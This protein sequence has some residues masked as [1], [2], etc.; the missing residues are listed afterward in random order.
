[1]L[2]KV[3]ISIASALLT[4]AL[5]AQEPDS[6][7]L[8]QLDSLL[9]QYYESMMFDSYEEKCNEC[10]YLISSCTDSLLRQWVA[11]RILEHYMEPPLMGEEAVGL[12]VYDNWFANGKVVIADEAVDFAAHLFSRF[13]RSSMVGMTAPE[14]ELYRPAGNTLVVPEKGK[15]TVMFFYDTSCTKCKTASALLPYAFDRYTFPIRFYAVYTGSDG[16][17][18]KTFQDNFHI[19]NA[20]V[21]LIHLWDPEISSDY[22]VKYGVISTPKLYLIDKEG[23]IDGRRLEVDNLVEL[24][25]VY[26]MFSPYYEEKEE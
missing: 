26:Q 9:Q 22:Q 16:D 18:W 10:D 23:V 8:V 7:R 24:L 12:Y 6:T 20:L 4:V 17:Q 21:E 3:L 5:S 25:N 15:V 11:T 14:I 1:M 13:N 2:K 19:E